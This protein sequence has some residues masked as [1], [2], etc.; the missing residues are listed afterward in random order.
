MFADRDS[1]TLTSKRETSTLEPKLLVLVQPHQSSRQAA[2]RD[3]LKCPAVRHGS[4]FD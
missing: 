4:P 1:D 2:R 3:P